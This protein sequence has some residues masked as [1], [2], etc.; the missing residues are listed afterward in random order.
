[1]SVSALKATPLEPN[2][3]KRMHVL[4]ANLP[5][6]FQAGKGI[7][8]ARLRAYPIPRSQSETNAGTPL[9]L[10]IR[11]SVLIHTQYKK[12]SVRVLM[13]NT[14]VDDRD[15]LDFIEEVSN[16]VDSLRKKICKQCDCRVTSGLHGSTNTNCAYY[17]IQTVEDLVDKT[18]VE[19]D[20]QGRISWGDL[21][22]LLA[23]TSFPKSTLTSCL[24]LCKMEL[25]LSLVSWTQP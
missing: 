14:D 2:V 11:T 13:Y 3:V 8:A 6:M 19:E 16:T 1:M 7:G 9:F 22:S 21:S 24:R 4:L 18:I 20:F 10:R 5:Q 15:N 17:P 23:N 12:K 25:F